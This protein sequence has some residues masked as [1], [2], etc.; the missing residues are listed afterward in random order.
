MHPEL[1]I[2]RHGETVWNAENRLQ[3]QRDS[4]LTQKGIAD[5]RRQKALLDDCDLEGFAF[6]TSPQGRAFQT[7]AIAFAG[8][9]SLIRTDDRLR[10]IGVGAWSGKLRDALPLPDGPN[11]LLAQYDLA[12]DGEGLAAVKARCAAF[13]ADLQGPAVIVTHG[14]TGAVLRALIIG[15]RA[16]HDP[17]PHAGQGCVLHLKDGV[18]RML[19]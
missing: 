16:F 7:A 4:P 11:P 1:Y 6:W 14:I 18:Q 2:L 12:P 15:D 10:E 17:S 9:A 5:A 13:L 8:H 19:E 3:G